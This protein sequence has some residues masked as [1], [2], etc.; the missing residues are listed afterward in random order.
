[1]QVS[2]SK[3]TWS[4]I[5]R[6]EAVREEGGGGGGGGNPLGSDRRGPKSSFRMLNSQ[7]ITHT[8]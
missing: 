7:L 2:A 3:E 8:G 5:G 4:Q 6:G 1:M